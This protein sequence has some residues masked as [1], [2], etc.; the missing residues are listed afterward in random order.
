MGSIPIFG[1]IHVPLAQPV[2]HLTFNQ[3]VRDSSSLRDTTYIYGN[4]RVAE[5]VDALDL[6]SNVR[7][8]VW[9]RL[10]SWVPFLFYMMNYK[11][12]YHADIMSL[13]VLEY[14][15]VAQLAR[16]FGSYPKGRGFDPLRRYQYVIYSYKIRVF[17]FHTKFYTKFSI[18]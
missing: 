11:T 1:T 16:A 9:V 17:L 5:L 14:G 8:N 15:G 3:G 4:A 13:C 7:K 6:K 10:P 2:E 12:A 18:S